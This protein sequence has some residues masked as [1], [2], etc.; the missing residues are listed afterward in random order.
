[1]NN[2]E[3]TSAGFVLGA[4]ASVRI[5]S[6]TGAVDNPPAVLRWSTAAIWSNT[7]DNVELRNASNEVVSSMW[8]GG[9]CP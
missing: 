6:Y 8:Y 7:G 2:W 9:G 1:L 5:E 4:G 3:P